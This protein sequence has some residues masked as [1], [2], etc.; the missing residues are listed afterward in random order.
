MPDKLY[1]ITLY[2]K[3]F[4][5]DLNHCIGKAEIRKGSKEFVLNT[6]KENLGL[7]RKVVIEVS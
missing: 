5:V 6:I 2:Y 7:T 1:R 3:D 4:L